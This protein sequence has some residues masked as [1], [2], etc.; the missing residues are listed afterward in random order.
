MGDVREV[1][2]YVL[3]VD[4]ARIDNDDVAV[5]TMR[6]TSGALSTLHITMRTHTTGEER[7]EV[8]GTRGTLV[9]RWPYHSTHTLEPAIIEVHERSRRVTDHTLSTSW[10][11]EREIGTHWQ[12]LNELRHFCAC[13]AEQREPAV[14]GREGYAV[15]EILN[16]AYLS[17][18]TGETVR[19]PLDRVPDFDAL[20]ARLRADSRWTIEDAD[21]TGWDWRY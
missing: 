16:A 3:V 2:A 14:G 10:C 13:I 5:V 15:V 18:Q 12:Y 11:P 9:M 6:H 1:H 21:I 7:Y 4:A 8:H 20:F 17:A 19:L